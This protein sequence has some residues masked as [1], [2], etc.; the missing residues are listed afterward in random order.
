MCGLVVLTAFSFMHAAS[1][2]ASGWGEIVITICLVYVL[3]YR[4]LELIEEITEERVADYEEHKVI[5]CKA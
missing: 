1:L 4:N 5:D 2:R 3:D